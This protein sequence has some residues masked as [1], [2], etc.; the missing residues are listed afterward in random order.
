MEL[1]YNYCLLY[2]NGNGKGFGVVNLQIENT[3]ILVDHI[4]TTTKE[5]A[6]KKTKLSIKIEKN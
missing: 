2:A 6:L 5:K 1:T 4:F 3:L